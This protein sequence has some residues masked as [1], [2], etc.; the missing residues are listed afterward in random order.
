MAGCCV[1]SF[2][3]QTIIFDQFV[4]IERNSRV[5]RAAL[6]LK[7]YHGY[8]WIEETLRILTSYNM[9]QMHTY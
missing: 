8:Q 2:Q 6:R 4:V 7:P 1:T 5:A 3:S 9:L